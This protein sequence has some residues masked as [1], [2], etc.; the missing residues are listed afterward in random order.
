[1][2]SKKTEAEKYVSGDAPL[3]PTFTTGFKRDLEVAREM[4]RLRQE[5]SVDQVTEEPE[6]AT[7]SAAR[8]YG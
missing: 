1:M 8:R 4:V 3:P 5:G 6:S 2:T 7:L